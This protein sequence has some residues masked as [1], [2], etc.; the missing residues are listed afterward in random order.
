MIGR[1]WEI[2][3]FS[4]TRR[5]D[6]YAY[7][8]AKKGTTPDSRGQPWPSLQQAARLCQM[9]LQTLLGL[10]HTLRIRHDVTQI[11]GRVCNHPL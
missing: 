8:D 6:G 11:E 7:T 2:L 1:C 9:I 3:P 4:G 10:N 5:V